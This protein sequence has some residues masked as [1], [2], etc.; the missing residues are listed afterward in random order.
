MLLLLSVVGFGLAASMPLGA[1]FLPRRGLGYLAA[2]FPAA[3]LAATIPVTGSVLQ[4]VPYV[5]HFAWAPSLD[6]SLSL[7][8]DGLS[9][10]F[11]WLISGIALV[12]FTYAGIYMAGSQYAGRFFTYL[13]LFTV[14]MLGLVTAGNL[15][16][17][18][19]FWELTS[20]T[21]YLLIGFKAH[22]AESR[23]A[24]LRAL[25]VTGGGGLA[26]LAG[27]L[28]LGSAGGSMELSVLLERGD[29]IQAHG[30]YVAIT[31][32][33][34]LGALTKS[35]QAPFHFWLPGA[36]A[37]PTPVSAFLHSATMVK[38]GVYLVARLNP[39]LGGTDWWTLPLVT[40]GAFTMI[41]GALR[42]PFKYD[43]KQILAYSTLSVLGMLMMLLG[44]GHDKAV[45]AALVVLAAH[46]LYKASLF[47]T[48]G[49]LDTATGSR[50]V[51]ELAGLRGPLRPLFITGLLGAVSMIGIPP[52][53]GFLAKETLLEAVLSAQFAQAVL[54]PV[55][56]VAG[57]GLIVAAWS[58]GVKPFLGTPGSMDCRPISPVLW[59]AP[60]VPAVFGLVLGVFP[61]LLGPLVQTAAGNVAGTPFEIKL[62]LWH[63]FTPALFLSAAMLAAGVLSVAANPLRFVREDALPYLRSL[64]ASSLF[65]SGFN[66]AM[67]LAKRTAG[68]LDGRSLSY[69][70]SIILLAF[71]MLGGIALSRTGLLPVPQ[72]TRFDWSEAGIGLL[73]VA[74]ALVV[75]FARS[76]LV[77]AAAL[78]AVGFGIAMLFF[79][80][81]AIDLAITQILV[82][83]LMVLL[84]VLVVYA[85]PQFKRLSSGA[86]IARDALIA[87]ALGLFITMMIW[88]AGV[89]QIQE[90]ISEFH[91][92]ASVPEAYGRNIVNVT[93]VDFRAL[94]TFGEIIVLMIAALGVTALMKKRK[95]A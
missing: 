38:A 63:G 62:A 41:M 22:S 83:T 17:L 35:A 65:D 40:I 2:I 55:T 29:I 15:V 90:P 93:L 82:E 25:L 12:V 61:S 60:L 6:L 58:A 77:A 14:S 57:V 80:Y 1:R 44:L 19:V 71:L 91:A 64:H 49:T 42:A 76:M 7:Y 81:G 92:R 20:I 85:F 74:G 26:L 50:D 75:L 36:M 8:L 39:V 31:I 23:A 52:L 47:L 5:E 94:D 48:A 33:V 56:A 46:G 24:A 72:L 66:L 69:G 34:L 89:V 4:G 32:L 18:F 11:V 51:R 86:H 43:L 88:I 28:L 73:I 30:S 13:V 16:S 78:G 27:I 68:L 95:A 70:L 21:S 87:G 53:A 59:A 67:K 9:L 10:L 54:L 3:V 79:F 84:F 37:A 45:K